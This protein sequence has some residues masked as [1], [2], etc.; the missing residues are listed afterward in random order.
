MANKKIELPKAPGTNSRGDISLP[1]GPKVLD[2]SDYDDLFGDTK[3]DV[4]KSGWTQFKE[5]FT[6]S[7]A[8]RLNTKDIVRNFLRT[9]APDGI[10]SAFGAYD[11]LKASVGNIKDTLERTNASDLEYI[12]RR[13][14]DYL[15]Q[16]KDYM[17]DDTFNNISAGLES[18]I[19]DYKY[20]IESTRDQTAI[21]AQAKTDSEDN[22]IQLALDNI[23]LSAKQDNARSERAAAYR[24]KKNRTEAGLRDVVDSKRFDFVARTM[25]RAVDNL[26]S[27][28]S[29]Q[30]QFDSGIKR[31]GL[32]LQFRTYMGIKD[33]VKLAETSLQVQVQAAEQLVRNTG[34]PDFMKG[35]ATDLKK[36]QR[37]GASRN[38]QGFV[39]RT[40]GAAHRGLQNYLGGFG[41]EVEDRLTKGLGSRL[42]EIVQA[43]RMTENGPSMWD[44]RYSMLGNLAGEI[45]GDV[46]QSHLIPMAGRALRPTATKMMN[47][48]GG[49]KH[50]QLGYLLDNIPAFAQEFV[51]N[52]QNQYGAKGILRDL[53]APYIPTHHLQDRVTNGNYQTI[54]QQAG[55]NQMTQRSIVEVIPG[56][57]SSAVQELRMIRTGRDDIQ[58]EVFDITTGKFDVEKNANQNLLNRI[59]PQTSIR[60]ASGT[61]N[62][63]LNTM[64]ADGKLSPEARKALAERMLRE[65]SNN[66][67]FDPEQYL[68]AHGYGNNV[69]SETSD[70]LASFFRSK[71]DFDTKG[72]MK[73][74]ADNHQLRQDWS[75]SFLDIRSISRDPF[76]EIQRLIESGRTE[77]LRMMGI[78]TTEGNQDKINYDRIWE[79]L[80]SGVTNT[81]PYAPGGSGFDPNKDD[82]SGTAGHKDFVGPAYGG[83]AHRHVN[84]MI[85][86]GRDRFTPEAKEARDAAA[87]RIRELRAKYGN[88][89]SKIAEMME[90]FKADPRGTMADGYGKATDYTASLMGGNFGDLKMTAKDKTAELKEKAESAYNKAMA[91]MA[92]GLSASFVPKGMDKL[93]DLY[94][95]FNASEPV[96]K[97]IDFVNGNLVD[98]N[99]KKII[100]KPSDITG[101]VIN[102]EGMTVASAREVAAGLYN[103]VGDPVVK[104]L[105]KMGNA[106]S[107]AIAKHAGL[108]AGAPNVSPEL[109]ADNPDKPAD[110]SL[111]PGEDVVITARGIENGEYYNRSTGKLVTSMADLNGDIVDRDGNVV[112]TAQE[113]E[114]GLYNYKT[115][116]PWRLTKGAAKLVGMV[117]K[118]GKLSGMTA[119]QL[120]FHAI[121]F[122]GKAA[123]GIASKT[124]NFFV[125]NQNAYLPD[126]PDP[127][128]TRRQ[129]KAGEYFDENGKVIKDFLDVYSLIY[130]MDGEPVIPQDQYKNLMNYDGTKHQLAKNKSLIGRT[131]MRGVRAIRSAYSSWAIRYW[132]GL[133]RKSA[134]AAG[135]VGRKLFGG[136]AKVGGNLLGKIF[137]KG[138]PEAAQNPTNIIL[139]Q[140]LQQLQ[141]NEPPPEER[142]GSW[143][144]KAKKRASELGDKVLA[145][146]K[147]K[148]GGKGIIAG[149]LGGLGKLMGGGKKKSEE[150]DDDGF[151]LSDAA[152]VAEIGDSLR[153]RGR[154]RGPGRLRKMG[155]WLKGSRLGQ[156]GARGL[157][158]TGGLLASGAG[159]LAGTAAAGSV[160]N[161]GIAIGSTIATGVAALLSAPAWL[162]IGG[163]VLVGGGAY[164]GY[165]AYKAAGDFKYLR[166]MQYGITS[167][168]NKLTVM[169]L[170]EFLEKNTDKTSATPTL[171]ITADNAKEIL[172]I[173]GVDY[174]DEPSL[175]AFSRWMDMRFK[176]VYLS[177][178]KALGALGQQS[179]SLY[180]IDDKVPEEL[181]AD[182]LEAVK[183]PYEGETPY[184]FND[185]PFDPDSKLDDTIPEIK[186]QFA[187][188]TEK[189]A[190]AKADK[191]KADKDKEA[192]TS[193]ADKAKTD[194]TVPAG[195]AAAAATVTASD[196]VKEGKDPDVPVVEQ[197][198][199]DVVKSAARVGALSGAAGTVVNIEKVGKELTSLQSIR[200]RAY[201][202]QT[203][204]IADVESL[205]TL[206]YVYSRDLTVDNGG[207]DYMGDYQVFLREAGTYLGMSTAVGSDSRNKL[208]VWLA[209][210][211][212]PVFRAYWGAALSKSPTAQLN[213]IESQLKIN[214][215]IAA[216]N[217]IMG[218]TNSMGDSIWDV[219]SIFEVTG[220]LSDLRTLAE[221]DLKYL[222]DVGD[223]DIAG[224]PTQKASDQVAG[225][226]NASMGGSFTDGVID[227]AKS[228]WDTTKSAVSDTYNKV[229]GWFGGGD[230][231]GNLTFIEGGYKNTTGKQVVATGV[232]F[233]SVAAG[234]GGKWEDVPMPTANGT[235]KGAAPTFNAAA[236]MVGIP[237]ELMFIIAG[238]ESGYKYDIQAQ[239]SVN[240]KT[241]ERSKQSSA[242]G[243][244]QFLNA[245]WD[246]VY[247]KVVAQFGAPPDDAAR[248]MRKDP[249]LQALAGALFI[250]ANYDRLSK[251]LGRPISDTDI[252]IAHFL[253]PG[254]AIKFLKADPSALG[255]Q[256]FKDEYSSNLTIFFV[257]GDKSKPRTIGEIYKLFDDKIAKYRT[258]GGTPSDVPQTAGEEVSPEK[259]AQEQA[260]AA[261]ATQAPPESSTTAANDPSYSSDSSSSGGGS[262]ADPTT[263]PSPG[264][265]IAGTA[266]GAPG[267]SP[268]TTNGLPSAG[269]GSIGQ[270]SGGSSVDAQRQA[271]E[272]AALQA[273]Q[274]RDQEL[275][276]SKQ[277]DST[278]DE[279][280]MKQLNTIIEIRDLIKTMATSSGATGGNA[281]NDSSGGRVS[282]GS[283]AGNSMNPPIQNRQAQHRESPMTLK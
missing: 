52:Q 253:G 60:S 258:G 212:A 154:K 36:F 82:M 210:R 175:M 211:F 203:L 151:G 171:N 89:A 149:L 120:G 221:A 193:E 19:D 172:S 196:L 141:A 30:E 13:A 266:P 38:G 200:M 62:D 69:K 277:S 22:T 15:P 26:S 50:N 94:S 101:A 168:G 86:K 98:L 73:D 272:E 106:A 132:K 81:N 161:A 150:D 107:E 178:C 77:P 146:A 139:A 165:R 61:I 105:A 261:Q 41:G 257:G 180:D 79:I 133:G 117:G 48:Y 53:I 92:P 279:I 96:I 33:L 29:Y 31:K 72:K 218:A 145:T 43:A 160:V 113:V 55:F 102:L 125:E 25:G 271:A 238:I 246:E 213:S 251:A 39:G 3:S 214:D 138:D 134:S 270:D 9:A 84:N 169:K 245:T 56:L 263:Q 100:V 21:R 243:W 244:F 186:E 262:G 1:G 147:D 184:K 35:S 95:Q 71:F 233:S 259:A 112:V 49:G 87:K 241:G 88:N 162:L 109:D 104:F 23:A 32:E 215:K 220:S 225:K 5:G 191:A 240:K 197:S 226:N 174:K 75:Q 90:Q 24:D 164:M 115:G 6:D 119:T 63:T 93:T 216:A 67:R 65:A 194:T 27:I 265:A 260:A 91:N 267:M 42:S 273:Q 131:V 17:S 229:A 205:L 51:N 122:M 137:E 54:D 176:P 195:T 153:G 143:K 248:T 155:R 110:L 236:A 10:S 209:A 66:K 182:L 231:D 224:T 123:L 234:N 148:D 217:A 202:L 126:S 177:Y 118:L 198:P 128:F 142:Q 199:A 276:K 121:K 46:V 201:G 58:K 207:V 280:R 250:K 152:D 20:A 170:E 45:S 278:V 157:A 99:T 228:A 254:G 219:A 18:K 282:T 130:G 124:F 237:A 34:T 264:K 144:D 173:M 44:Q 167:T 247:S 4:K 11:E 269:Q 64:D 8:N 185:N 136:A 14:Q 206:E 249:R 37:Q 114:E 12:A 268:S 256:V 283:N 2:L 179:V 129:L 255:Y 103:R 74:T 239:P 97:A 70:E 16:L 159:A 189:F 204:G 252:Y 163:A 274:R 242:Y 230:K 40:A 188:L 275:R 235:A 59:I 80:R 57:L 223:K 222:K 85:R 281:A 227:S 156:L 83:E 116:K 140:I 76:K 166:M 232:T 111:A 192:A 190:G 68:K 28:K 187:K 7:L 135:W 78:I 183:F 158:A 108:H 127:V 208:S 47:K 181:K